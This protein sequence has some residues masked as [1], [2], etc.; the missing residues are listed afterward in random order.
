MSSPLKILISGGGIAGGSLAFWLVKLGH[1]V[2]VVE[3]FPTLRATGLQI[4]LRGHGIEV[5]KRMGLEEAF[6]AKS[7]PEQ[8]LQFVD[9]SGRRRGHFPMNHSGSGV[10]DFTSEY[11]I[12][13]GDLCRLFYDATRGRAKYIFGT[14]VES[15]HQNNG[16]VNVRFKDGNT[17]HFDLLVGADGQ[18]SRTRKMMLKSEASDGFYPLR[19]IHASYFTIPRPIEKGEE[20]YSTAYFATNSRILM[21]RRHSPEAIQAYT[22]FTSH[23]EEFQN[24]RRTHGQEVKDVVAKAFKGAGWQVDYFLDAMRDS[25]DF[26][27]EQIGLVKIDHWSEGH[28]ALLGDA[29]Y[30]PS[31][32]TGMGTTSAIVGAYVLAGEIG[33][34]CGSS[35]RQDGIEAALHEYE[36]KMRPFMDQ[37]QEGI[38]DDALVYKLWPTG[39]IGMAILYWI[40]G[41]VSFFHMNLGKWVLKE[42]AVKWNLPN[43]EELRLDETH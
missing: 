3:W 38:T 9:G 22:F 39:P 19:G 11:E 13:R 23:D 25:K 18:G 24:A 26:Y 27:C 28:V 1:D 34:Y 15:F 33:K 35:R 31:S 29:A 41:I 2:T 12:M 16:G 43:Y 42:S 32:M 6:R 5:L 7:V 14:S 10:Q 36:R 30:G 17:D 4:D 20:Y 8:G 40:I 37:V 21:T